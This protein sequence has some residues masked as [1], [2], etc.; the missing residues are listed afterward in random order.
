M[1]LRGLLGL[2]LGLFATG[3]ASAALIV[4]DPDAFAGGTNISN[5]FTNVTL[6][7]P[8]QGDPNVYSLVSGLAS[9]GTRIFGSGSNGIEW[10]DGF[11]AGMRADFAGGTNFVSIDI[12]GN[13]GFDVGQLQAFNAANILIGSYTTSGLGSGQVETASV[14]V[15]G[16][17]YVIAT[18]SANLSESVSLDN[19]A[20]DDG[21][22]VAVPI[23][24]AALGGVALLGM[25]GISRVRRGK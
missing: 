15:A 11:N 21:A 24:A 25:M 22:S 13:D 23:P 14:S 16:I 6:S 17:A 20:Y 5:S 7:G 9:T 1:K 19:L 8:G 2:A 10:G 18:G 3:T 12:I 4:V